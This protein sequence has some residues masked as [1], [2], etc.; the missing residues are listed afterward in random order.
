MVGESCSCEWLGERLQ[1]AALITDVLRHDDVTSENDKLN[2][3]DVTNDAERHSSDVTQLRVN[4]GVSPAP[5]GS[6]SDGV[7]L[8]DCR[9]AQAYSRAHVRGALLVTLPS[10]VLRRLQRG[11]GSVTAAV[12]PERRA[13]FTARCRTG[14]VVLYNEAGLMTSSNALTS[15]TVVSSPDGDSVT[16]AVDDDTTSS[17]AV[18]TLLLTRLEADGC[19]VRYLYGESTRR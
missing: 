4:G 8:L 9:P 6:D 5:R 1:A 10:L 12:A 3:N 2:R 19:R 16:S 14:T 18:M 17:G 13:S 7:V 11:A 15:S